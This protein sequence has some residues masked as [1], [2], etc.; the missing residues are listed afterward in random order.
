ML[1]K[2]RRLQAKWGVDE[3]DESK[4][5][6]HSCATYEALVD[7]LE[8]L[9]TNGASLTNLEV[10]SK[11]FGICLDL[12]SIPFDKEL[13]SF[14]GVPTALYWDTQHILLGSGSIG[15][16]ETNGFLTRVL[17]NT[18]ITLAD[19]DEFTRTWHVP[20]GWTKLRPRFFTER[21]NT[22]KDS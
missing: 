10:V 5:A 7:T 22:A 16:F 9:S 8:Q 20:K 1:K 14:V 19:I 13:R 15:Q 4:F 2:T 12:G 17:H 11:D 3:W 18:A 6:R 21:Y